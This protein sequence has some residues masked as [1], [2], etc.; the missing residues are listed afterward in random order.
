MSHANIETG[1]EI[2]FTN[3]DVWSFTEKRCGPLY[4]GVFM[5]KG[6]FPGPF[7]ESIEC[8]DWLGAILDDALKGGAVLTKGVGLSPTS[9]PLQEQ[10]Q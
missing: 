7:T 2:K 9:L 8:C 10:P 1:D 4:M 3:G 6:S 5:A